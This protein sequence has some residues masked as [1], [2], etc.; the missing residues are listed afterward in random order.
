MAILKELLLYNFRNYKRA[1][2][3]LSPEINI[4]VGPN[5]HGKTNCLESIALLIAGKSFRTSYLKELITHQKEHFIIQAHFEKNGIDQ[6]LQIDYS[7]T[8]KTIHYNDT[9]YISFLPL[10]GVLNGVFFSAFQNQLVKGSPSIRRRFLDL[11]TAQIDPLYLHHLSRYSKALKE[12]NILLKKRKLNSIELYEELLSKSAPYITLKRQAVL[13]SLQASLDSTTDFQ[14]EKI[15]LK[16]LN[17]MNFKEKDFLNAY[18]K[19]REKELHYGSSLVGPHRD[20]ILFYL[21]QK[22]TKKF[23]SEGQVQTFITS[24]YLAEYQRLL[25]E[26]EQ[27]PIFCIDDIGQSL[28][29]N[30]LNTLYQSLDQMGQVFIT[31]PHRPNYNFKSNVKI[32]EVNNG[33]ITQKD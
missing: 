23:A 5:G 7:P 12:R 28:D 17:G 33:S 21:N 8:K 14:F 4:F 9:K 26:T 10:I 22:E 15:S 13:E 11:Q 27:K 3:S 2:I 19:N 20:D 31:L 16:Y 1:K 32:F 30:R 29:Q 24:I 18:Q 6:S 25:K